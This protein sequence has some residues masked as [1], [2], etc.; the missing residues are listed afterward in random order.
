MFILS[1]LKYIFKEK[2]NT[3]Q[4]PYS[5]IQNSG[6]LNKNLPFFLKA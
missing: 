1:A 5:K 2:K 3:Q 4:E 6:F